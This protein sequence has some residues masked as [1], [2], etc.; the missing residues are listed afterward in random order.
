VTDSDYVQRRLIDQSA[1]R[2][3]PPSPVDFMAVNDSSN[4]DRL[5][6]RIHG[7]DTARTPTGFAEI[8][9]DDFP[10]LRRKAEFCLFCSLHGNDKVIRTRAI[11]FIISASA[12]RW[13]KL[14][15]LVVAFP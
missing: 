9:S 12:S 7:W 5:P 4:P 13:G 10:A 11:T 14:I 3:L 1:R 6:A 2:R 8:V 15:Y